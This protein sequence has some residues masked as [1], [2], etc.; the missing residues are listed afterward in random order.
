MCVVDKP[1]S[2]WHLVKQP[3][4]AKTAK[5]P[6]RIKKQERHHLWTTVAGLLPLLLQNSAVINGRHCFLPLWINSSFH[7][8][9]THLKARVLGHRTSLSKPKS[10]VHALAATRQQDGNPASHQMRNSMRIRKKL[11][12]DDIIIMTNVHYGWGYSFSQLPFIKAPC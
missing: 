2:L 10:Y 5:K 4:W 12:T 6:W 8:W 7:L 1:L 3:G 9:V 11:D